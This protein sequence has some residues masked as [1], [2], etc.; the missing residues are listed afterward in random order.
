M[1]L[2]TR[3]ALCVKCKMLNTLTSGR[4][5][6]FLW[7]VCL[8]VT[9]PAVVGDGPCDLE[10]GMWASP[11]AACEYAL[12]PDEAIKRFG[13]RALIEL[14]PG[15]YRYEGAQCTIFSNH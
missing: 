11:A 3:P 14:Q 1:T 8:L 2:H 15:F 5:T 13:G 4:P 6:G 10:T 7:V 9:D 12:K